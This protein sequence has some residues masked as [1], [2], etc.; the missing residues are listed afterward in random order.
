[1][2]ELL[3]NAIHDMRLMDATF[4]EYLYEY[5][6][7]A[8]AKEVLSYEGFM[9]KETKERF[10]KEMDDSYKRLF[11]ALAPTEVFYKK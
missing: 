5:K 9:K 2:N 11:A 8:L 7:G 3:K 10:L 6:N 1:M 4:S